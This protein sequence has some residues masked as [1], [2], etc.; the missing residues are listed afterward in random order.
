ME[1]KGEKEYRE[2]VFKNKETYPNLFELETKKN[3]W[4]FKQSFKKR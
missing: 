3:R 4:K 1:S 2:A